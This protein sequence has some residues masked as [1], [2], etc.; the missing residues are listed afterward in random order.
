MP[1][2]GHGYT[3]DRN[4]IQDS[5]LPAILPG[6]YATDNFTSIWIKESN[7]SVL[8]RDCWPGRS[9]WVDFLNFNA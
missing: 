4:L 6:S 1:N 2:Y 7:G 5:E 8:F 3:L 9:H